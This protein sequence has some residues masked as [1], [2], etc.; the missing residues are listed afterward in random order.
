[1]ELL[2][3]WLFK[4]LPLGLFVLGY[5]VMNIFI[6]IDHNA[7]STVNFWVILLI[8][9]EVCKENQKKIFLYKNLL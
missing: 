3:S 4:Q 6:I 5:D 8:P 1:M 9:R 2:G 7:H